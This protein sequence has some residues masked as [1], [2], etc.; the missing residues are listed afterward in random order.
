[1]NLKPIVTEKAVMKI[2][3]ENLLTFA[4]GKEKTKDEIKK[5]VEELFEVKVARVR[6]LV[7]DNKKYAYVKLKKEFLA[8][9]VVTKLGLM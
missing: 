2:E 7:R 9:D 3:S 4:T 6:T 5:E 1:M 8:I